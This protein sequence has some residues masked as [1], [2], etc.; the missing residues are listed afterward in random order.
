MIV[1]PAIDLRGGSAVRLVE[2][3]F[4]RETRFFADPLEPARRFAEQ[5][6]DWIHVVDLDAARG[7]GDN[8]EVI[9]RLRGELDLRIQV[10][11]GVVDA[12]LLEAGID[13]VVIGS[14]LTRDR[15]AAGRLVQQ[16]PGRVA[17]G[18]DHRGGELRVGGWQEGSGVSL[19]DVLAWPE[20]QPAAAVVVTDIAS[21]G[22]L[23][24][25]SLESLSD[26]VRLA[27]CPVI[28]SGGVGTLDDIRA[29]KGTGVDGVIIGR[30]LYDAKFDL[31]AALEAA[32]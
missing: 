30:A 19:I 2:G 7:H 5:G 3:D 11:G 26:V 16:H 15:R 21:D 17:L 10:G 14:L 1:Y 27:A 12:S 8:R 4:A 13:R 31:A 9:A 18:L 32:G 22:T 24:G 25:P 20:V 29:L 28:A 6:A 23:A